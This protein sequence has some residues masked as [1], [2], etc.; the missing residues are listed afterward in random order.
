MTWFLFGLLALLYWTV[1]ANSVEQPV[2]STWTILNEV[3]VNWYEDWLIAKNPHYWLWQGRVTTNSKYFDC[4]S[5]IGYYWFKLGIFTTGELQNISAA[6]IKKYSKTKSI[7]DAKRWDML[8]MAWTNWKQNHIAMI[9][10]VTLSWKNVNITIVDNMKNKTT[11]TTFNNVRKNFNG[12]R[13]YVIENVLIHLAK[14]RNTPMPTTFTASWKATRYDYQYKWVRVTKTKST[15]ALRITQRY[16]HYIVKNVDTWK[17]V[18]CTQT[19][20]WPKEYTNKV[21]DLSSYAFKQIWS[22]RR[23]VINVSIGKLYVAI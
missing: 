19:D 6:T 9:S 20:Y 4:S 15:C 7:K 22:L 3:L 11:Y 1:N 8:Y 13:M 10:N 12:Y 18:V 17:Y 21:I 16:A 5:L 23:W 2:V 14:E